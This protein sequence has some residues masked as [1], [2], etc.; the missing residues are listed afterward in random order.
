M[1]DLEA[2]KLALRNRARSLV[3]ATTGVVSLSATAT[4]FAR[5]TGS[6][7]TDGF[8]EG[9]E[10]VAAGFGIAGNNGPRVVANVQ[11]L[12]VTTT[13]APAIEAAAGGRS[14]VAGLP[15]IRSWENKAAAKV[16][17][18]PYIDE[19]FVPATHV[20]KSFPAQGGIAEETGLY[21]ITW[22]GLENADTGGINRPVSALKALFAPGTVV[23]AA[24]VNVRIRSDVAPQG[25][26][27][28]PQG[29][30]WAA[31]QLRIPWRAESLNAIAP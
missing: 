27:I 10:F 24:G 3:V 17:G 23:V 4:G 5:T 2:T 29:N 21:V 18:R 11:P 19:N 28:I 30:G 15:L 31:C 9:E 6:F 20:L 22:F 26:Q 16:A 14:L 12:L 8:A 7:V 1:I 13:S 25:G